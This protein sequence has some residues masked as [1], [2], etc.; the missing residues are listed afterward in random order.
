MYSDQIKKNCRTIC[1]GL[2]GIIN[3]EILQSVEGQLSD[4]IWENSSKM[5]GYWLFEHI[6]SVDG[7]VVIC[8]SNQYCEY[9]WNR[10]KRNLFFGMRDE[11]IKAWFAKKIKQIVKIDLKDNAPQIKWKRGEDYKLNYIGYDY[12]I[13]INDC[14]NAYDVLL[15]RRAR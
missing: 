8:I 4:G 1:T 13:S 6:D 12:D 14:Y 7:E 9:R 2:K 11:D 5:D 15:N 3:K 10:V